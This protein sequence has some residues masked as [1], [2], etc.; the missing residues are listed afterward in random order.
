MAAELIGGR[1]YYTDA[2]SLTSGTTNCVGKGKIKGVFN[3]TSASYTFHFPSGTVTFT[4][5]TAS[6]IPFAPLGVTFASGSA[7]GLY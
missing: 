7:Y 5:D 1:E 3:S 4:P 2:V 6:V